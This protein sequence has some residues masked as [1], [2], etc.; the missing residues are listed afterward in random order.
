[1]AKGEYVIHSGIGRSIIGRRD[2]HIF[3]SKCFKNHLFENNSTVQNSL[4][5][6]NMPPLSYHSFYTIGFAAWPELG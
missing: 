1:M 5:N 6:I 2:I 3:V 4:Q